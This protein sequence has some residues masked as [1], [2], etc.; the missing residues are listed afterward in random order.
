[1]HARIH[2]RA[3]THSHSHV[4]LHAT[5]K[6]KQMDGSKLGHN[7]VVQMP[8]ASFTLSDIWAATQEVAK[9]EG[10]PLGSIRQVAANAGA[11]SV[12]E[13][14]V[15][16]VVSCDLAKSLGFPMD[17]DLKSIIRDY[18]KTYIKKA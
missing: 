12:K 18:I 14:N 17:T 10:V 7:R 11:T 8:C 15:C 1:M 4:H 16:P 9:E 2:T 5:H 13:I 6:H 3:Y